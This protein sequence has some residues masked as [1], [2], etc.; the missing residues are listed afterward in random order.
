MGICRIPNPYETIID[1]KMSKI[2]LLFRWSYLKVI[3][4]LMVALLLLFVVFMVFLTVY[5]EKVNN[6]AQRVF[7][8]SEDKLFEVESSYLLFYQ[9][10][11]YQLIKHYPEIPLSIQPYNISALLH[12]YR[13]KSNNNIVNLLNSR[14]KGLIL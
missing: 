4:I 7:R 6:D 1:E 5:A 14:V 11:E 2:K 3:I 9:F 12:D 8:Y 10:Y 13:T